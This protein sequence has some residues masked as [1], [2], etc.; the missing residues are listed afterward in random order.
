MAIR[1][2]PRMADQ[3]ARDATRRLV[4][5]GRLVP[6]GSGWHAGYEVSAEVNHSAAQLFDSLPADDQRVL[7]DATQRL[8]A[9]VTI[10]SKNPCADSSARSATI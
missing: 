2:R 5:I 8:V 1:Q 9:M 4:A 10:W 6:A 7:D 3:L